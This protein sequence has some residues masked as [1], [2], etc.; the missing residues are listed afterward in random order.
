MLKLEKMGKPRSSPFT[1]WFGSID[2][3]VDRVVIPDIQRG[4]A[5]RNDMVDIVAA[6]R[7][8]ETEGVYNV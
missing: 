8:W 7:C 1:I 3:F 6:I 5:D 2:A 4:L